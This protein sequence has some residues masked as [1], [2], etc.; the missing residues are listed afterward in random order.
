ML[1]KV[2]KRSQL[3]F[4]LV[5]IPEVGEKRPLQ[6]MQITLII[7]AAEDLCRMKDS[8]LGEVRYKRHL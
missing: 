7:L 1:E 6:K 3:R 8:K 2:G 5:C 4:D